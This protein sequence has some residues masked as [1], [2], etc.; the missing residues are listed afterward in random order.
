MAQNETPFS[1][2]TGK[3]HLYL[4]INT[5]A[6]EDTALNKINFLTLS[7]KVTRIIKHCDA[8]RL[9]GLNQSTVC[10]VTCLYAGRI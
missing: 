5:F 9:I 3:D 1:L 7:L 4:W 2:H 10:K 6:L 8:K